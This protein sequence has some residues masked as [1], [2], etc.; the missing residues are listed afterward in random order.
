MKTAFFP[1]VYKEKTVASIQIKVLPADV[2]RV[3]VS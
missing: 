3:L 2:A 1:N